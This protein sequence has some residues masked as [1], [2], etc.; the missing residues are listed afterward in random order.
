M[1][2]VVP[3]GLA[4]LEPE[5]RKET[6]LRIRRVFKMVIH[7]CVLLLLVSGLYNTMG[8]WEIYNRSRHKNGAA[9]SRGMHLLLGLTIFAIAIYVTMGK[10]PPEKHGKW[11]MANLV[12]MAVTIAVAG[13]LKY[14]RDHRVGAESR[15][16]WGSSSGNP[17]SDLGFLGVEHAGRV[18]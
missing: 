18:I 5:V 4:K 15:R 16:R 10:E 1:R 3:V 12:L 6:F 17:G 14:V 9:T 2:V 11:V 7:T 13:G 8:N